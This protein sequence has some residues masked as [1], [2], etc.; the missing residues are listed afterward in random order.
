MCRGMSRTTLAHD[1]AVD[2]ALALLDG[3][4]ILRVDLGRRQS[5][6]G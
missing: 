6:G 1:F 4:R 5:A 3:S 2:P